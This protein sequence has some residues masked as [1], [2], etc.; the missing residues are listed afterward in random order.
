[1]TL[2]RGAR[3]FLAAAL[4]TTSF[5]R[6]EDPAPVSSQQSASETPDGIVFNFQ[7]ADMAAVVKTVSQLTGKNFLLDQRVKG[8]LTIIS[9]KPVSRAAA[10]QIFISAL[11]SQGL[12][13]VEGPG[14][15]VKIVPE[16]EARLGAGVHEGG[17]PG[18]SDSYV[19]QIVPIQYA[20]AN[21]L[22]ASFRQLLEPTGQV[23]VYAPT[24]TLIITAP[25]TSV[26]NILRVIDGIDRPGKNDVTIIPLANASAMDVA[27]LVGRL[28]ESQG[29]GADASLSI[30]PDLRT[31]SLLIRADNPA[32]LE[33]I[34]RLVAQLDVQAKSGGQSRVIY[35]RHAEAT[36]LAEIIRGLLNGAKN[37]TP[38]SAGT[39]DS[40]VQA[41]EASNSLIVNGPDAI[42]NNVQAIV[43]KLDI[44]RAQVYVEALIAEV[45]S[46][47]AAEFGVQFQAVRPLNGDQVA[48][49][50]NFPLAGGNQAP[51]QALVSPN[52][53]TVG[54]LGDGVRLPDGTFVPG[55][56]G[57]VRAL[58]QDSNSNILSTPNLLTLDNSEAKI[59]IGQNVPF[60]T[61]RYTQTTGSSGVVPFQTIERHDVGLTLKLKPQISDGGEI[62]LQIFQE[63]SSV[64][65]A[66]VGAQDIITN[67]RSLETTVN[68][69]DGQI[70]AL[71]G[72]IQD[73]VTDSVNRVPIL[74][75]IPLIG[76]LFTFR[77]RKKEKIN[78]M[79]FLRPVI[80]RSP[81]DMATIT[82]NRYDYMRGLQKGTKME[83]T[84]FI[85]RYKEPALPEQPAAAPVPA[86]KPPE[87]PSHP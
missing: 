81:N 54:I 11:K 69:G 2:N 56:A 48:G 76:E 58:E 73:S 33:S 70:V 67:K 9:S 75:H 12:A 60:L 43:D 65:P 68:V 52:G 86:V 7:D 32:R 83:F 77:S 35:L 31:N 74:G 8:K 87:A 37:S 17:S 25:A 16:N 50:L 51:A 27:Q 6:A 41:D 19:T 26:R 49:A 63:V 64:V 78:L 55:L 23:Y 66:T 20:S 53:V 85:P 5:V 30:I 39:V 4:A 1:M 3:L 61:G 14:D 18:N 47:R 62:R 84:P 40:L 42:Y 46:T 34:R 22:A 21:Q 57:L 82:N 79:V 36:K 71:G 28:P 72:L 10:Y 45:S 59:V 44:P 24:N 13:A 15:V 29:G 38:L 80:V